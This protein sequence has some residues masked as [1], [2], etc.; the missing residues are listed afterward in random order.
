M[1]VA[2]LLVASSSIV[3]ADPDPREKISTA[4]DE[5]IRLLEA[6]EHLEFVKKFAHPDD[7]KELLDNEGLSLEELAEKFGEKGAAELLAVLKYVKANGPP[8]YNEQKTKATFSIDKAE[9]RQK[10]LQFEKKGSY[11]YVRN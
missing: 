4:I 6:K 2:I 8:S 10:T 1:F 11:W 9:F 3:G 5:G 7:I